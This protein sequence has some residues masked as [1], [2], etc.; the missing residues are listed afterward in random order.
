MKKENRKLFSAEEVK[1]LEDNFRTTN[2]SIMGK[3]LNRS[4]DVV[5]NKLKKLKLVRT[6]EERINM[7]KSKKT[8][9]PKINRKIEGGGRNEHK[10]RY[11]LSKWNKEKGIF[12]EKKMLFYKN[13]K[14]DDYNDLILIKSS[15]FDVMFEKR[16]RRLLYE[17][18]INMA[19]YNHRMSHKSV[20]VKNREIENQKR[21]DA[22]AE[23]FKQKNVDDVIVEQIN[24]NKVPIVVDL[25]TTIWVN[26]DKC[27]NVNGAWIRK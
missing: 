3:A 17:E 1:Y 10:K 2:N 11:H 14:Y 9:L 24:Q 4:S 7:C 21:L 13:G 20:K 26:I 6:E 22:F 27:V 23:T 8:V 5:Q 18:K 12:N 25:K 19:T 16:K 15:S